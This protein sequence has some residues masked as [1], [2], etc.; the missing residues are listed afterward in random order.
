M[1]R[2]RL[3]LHS[4]LRSHWEHDRSCSCRLV[5]FLPVSNTCESDALLLTNLFGLT[6]W[7]NPVPPKW[8][9]YDALC[10]IHHSGRN[11][12]KQ[13]SNYGK[14]EQ[15]KSLRGSSWHRYLGFLSISSM[16]FI[17]YIKHDCYRALYDR[18]FRIPPVALYSRRAV[19]V[20][21]SI[22]GFRPLSVRRRKGLFG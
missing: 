9:R 14:Q 12:S 10:D 18:C 8:A 3:D 6:R 19:F 1:S 4:S 13:P 17:L 15:S 2:P 5:R 7:Y 16:D 21:I 20:S 22:S 11:S